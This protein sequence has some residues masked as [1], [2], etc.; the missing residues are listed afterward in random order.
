MRHLNRTSWVC[1][2]GNRAS[3]L[4][5]CLSH[6]LLFWTLQLF[7]VWTQRGGVE[8]FKVKIKDWRCRLKVSG[9]EESWLLRSLILICTSRCEDIQPLNLEHPICENCTKHSARTNLVSYRRHTG[10]FFR[11]INGITSS[12]TWDIRH[13]FIRPQHGVMCSPQS[14]PWKCSSSELLQSNT[15]R[16]KYQT[17]NRAAKFILYSD[18]LVIY[19]IPIEEVR[20]SYGF[21]LYSPFPFLMEKNNRVP[22]HKISMRGPCEK[23][24]L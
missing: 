8:W 1:C 3:S 7:D 18:T 16:K 24:R 2:E 17:N 15:T 10:N 5:H 13:A 11:V 22:C 19:K 23:K 12:I 4:P 14:E 20:N 21:I 9:R 6:P